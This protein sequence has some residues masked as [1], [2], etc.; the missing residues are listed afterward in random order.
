M[1]MIKEEPDP[2]EL[3][4]IELRETAVPLNLEIKCEAEDSDWEMPPVKVE[5]KEE[6]TVE[7]ND[8]LQ[9]IYIRV[10][11]EYG[12]HHNNVF[13]PFIATTFFCITNLLVEVQL[14]SCR[15]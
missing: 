12:L 14:Q 2:S 1:E 11:A 6:V 15:K 10:L 4:E 3:L 7:E 5:I 8:V 13:L 9:S